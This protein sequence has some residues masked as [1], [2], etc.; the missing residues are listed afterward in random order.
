MPDRRKD[1]LHR[2]VWYPLVLKNFEADAP[3]LIHVR[4]EDPCREVHDWWL[5]WKCVWKKNLQLESGVLP[6]RLLQACDDRRPLEDVVAQRD[7]YAF[8]ADRPL[9]RLQVTADSPLCFLP[10][11]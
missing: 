8:F 1:L 10:G 7:L 4:V 3:V 5:A 2:E 6:F 9:N 11:A